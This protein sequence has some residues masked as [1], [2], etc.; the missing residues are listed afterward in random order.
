MV[1]LSDIGIQRVNRASNRSI[2]VQI[3]FHIQVLTFSIFLVQFFG[4]MRNHV[5]FHVSASSESFKAHV[6]LVFLFPGMNSLMSVHRRFV[7]EFL[8][9]NW[10]WHFYS[11]LEARSGPIT[12]W[13]HIS[14]CQVA[15]CREHFHVWK[16]SIKLCSV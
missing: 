1:V 6:T 10:T 3:C 2:Q 8:V 12:I 13:R 14:Y 15:F 9:A 11:F 16:K 5:K 4:Q 7:G